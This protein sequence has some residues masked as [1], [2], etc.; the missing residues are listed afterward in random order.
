MTSVKLNQMSCLAYDPG[1][2][3]YIICV[4][5]LECCSNPD[6]LLG[7]LASHLNS[8]GIMLLATDNRFGL[9]YFCGDRDR[10]TGSNF[11]GIENYCRIK[12]DKFQKI[13]GR[14][15]SREEVI[16]M[17]EKAG[18]VCHHCYSVYPSIEAAQLIFYGL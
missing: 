10:F 12:Y 6:N 4:G 15:F 2:Y 11:D 17:L 16:A 3:D 1:M 5:I 13:D 8:G 9:R 14:C 7:I 18:L